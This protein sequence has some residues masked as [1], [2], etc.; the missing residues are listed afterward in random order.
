MDLSRNSFGGQ[1]QSSLLKYQ[2]FSSHK[3]AAVAQ[4][5]HKYYSWIRISS[6]IQKKLWDSTNRP[7]SAEASRSCQTI[8][9]SS[10]T[11]YSLPSHDKW[12]SGP[13]CKVNQCQSSSYCLWG[14]IQIL[15]KHRASSQVSASGKDPFTSF[16]PSKRSHDITK[17][18]RK[19]EISIAS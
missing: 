15:S 16:C 5:T 11:S 1:I 4:S 10:L 17:F 2:Q 8:T 13:Q 18:P 9:R 19:P 3:S 7:E 12:R 14:Q 6:L